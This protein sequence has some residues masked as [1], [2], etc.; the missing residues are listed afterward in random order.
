[1]SV[2]V[3]SINSSQT[4]SF[5]WNVYLIDATLG[6]I[7]VTLPTPSADGEN[8]SL[9]RTDAT[10]NTVT[11]QGLLGET[12]DGASSYNLTAG[13]KLKVVAYLGNWWSYS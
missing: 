7:T 1:M 5:D 9:S 2:S 6:S 13:N 4:L 10:G 8:I 12:I 11:V 3:T